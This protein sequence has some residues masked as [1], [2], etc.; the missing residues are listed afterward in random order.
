MKKKLQTMLSFLQEG[1]AYTINGLRFEIAEA[2]GMLIVRG[3]SKNIWFENLEK[4][5]CLED[6]D[7]IKLK[8]S[9]LI[10]ESDDLAKFI[11]GKKIKYELDFDDY[12]KA[13]IGI[14]TE[15]DNEIHWLALCKRGQSS[16]LDR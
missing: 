13:S 7:E 14:C 8:F 16:F 1:K 9:E 11:K 12:G 6:L 4:K 3:W 5:S 10:Q 2:Q 15:Y